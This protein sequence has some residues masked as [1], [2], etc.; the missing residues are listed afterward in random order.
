MSSVGGILGKVSVA[1]I[2]ILMAFLAFQEYQSS[3]KEN[4]KAVQQK[5]KSLGS[6]N[7]KALEPLESDLGLL[8]Q[9][10]TLAQKLYSISR[11]LKKENVDLSKLSKLYMELDSREEFLNQLSPKIAMIYQTLFLTVDEINERQAKEAGIKF[12]DYQALQ[13]SPALAARAQDLDKVEFDPALEA[14]VYRV[15]DAPSV[16]EEDIQDVLQLCRHQRDCVEASI[17][18]W[19]DHHHLLSDQQLDW[20]EQSL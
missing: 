9:D 8:F 19:I 5:T 20:I 10:E 18:V 1:L 7:R 6:L 4:S 17:K 14:L 12:T 15:A 2:A 16:R 3:S 11:E 13:M